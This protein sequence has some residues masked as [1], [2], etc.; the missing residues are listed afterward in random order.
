MTRSQSRL[1]VVLLACVAAAGPWSGA[2]GQAAA[3]REASSRGSGGRW[4]DLRIAVTARTEPVRSPTV[5]V[6]VPLAP[7]AATSSAGQAPSFWRYTGVGLIA[8]SAVG[9]VA[10]L[11]Y[12]A[13][14]ACEMMYCTVVAVPAGAVAGTVGGIVTWAIRR[15]AW[16]PD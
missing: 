14:G 13:G 6:E 15:A 16:S 3:P 12:D 9:L 8:G 5:A 11:A 7:P 10:G 4:A 2:H 1:R